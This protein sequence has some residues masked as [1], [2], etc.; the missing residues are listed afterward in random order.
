M[1]DLSGGSWFGLA[2]AVFAAIVSIIVAYLKIKEGREVARANVSVTDDQNIREHLWKMVGKLEED[3]KD[4]I[5]ENATLH[6]KVHTLERAITEDE[7]DDRV[8]NIQGQILASAVHQRM[9]EK[10]A[11][12]TLLQY[13]IQFLLYAI[14]SGGLECPPLP[15]QLPPSGSGPLR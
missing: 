6:E 2:A 4:K 11:Q 10:D 5:R 3:L 15:K 13:Q 8:N 9:A 1:P 14:E 12:I 7:L